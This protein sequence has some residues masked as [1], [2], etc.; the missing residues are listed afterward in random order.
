M[1]SFFSLCF[2]GN[3]F[4]FDLIGGG[5]IP[6]DKMMHFLWG[7]ELQAI[8][9]HFFADKN[10]ATYFVFLSSCLK[11]GYDSIDGDRV[12]FDDIVAGMIGGI[13]YRLL[14]NSDIMITPKM[15]RIRIK[16]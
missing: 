13:S 15:I 8:G 11:E 9:E 3:S 10:K 4:A 12:D 5:Y 2:I 16:I 1:V 7:G 14:T 6:D